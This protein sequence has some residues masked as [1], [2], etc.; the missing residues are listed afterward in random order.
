MASYEKR[1][2]E[3]K[4]AISILVTPL[5]N[6]FT[7]L[8]KAVDEYIK[9][10]DEVLTDMYSIAADVSDNLRASDWKEKLA[11][12]REA[13]RKNLEEALRSV[14]VPGKAALDFQNK[15]V[16]DE[17]IFWK[18]FESLDVGPHRDVL[19]LRRKHLQA[20]HKELDEK[21]SATVNENRPFLEDCRRATKELLEH[22][23]RAI[24]QTA[25]LLLKAKN[26]SA[27]AYT[28]LKEAQE[29][30]SSTPAGAALIAEIRA[31]LLQAN[32]RYKDTIETTEQTLDVMRHVWK[33]EYE[34]RASLFRQSLIS[35][36]RVLSAVPNARRVTNEFLEKGGVEVAR[37]EYE[38][39][40]KAIEHWS[41]ELPTDGLK[42]DARDIARE[43]TAK[44]NEHIKEMDKAFTEFTAKHK[45]KL[46][47]EMAGDI[48]RELI[49]YENGEYFVSLM[50]GRGL[51]TKLREWNVDGRR[52]M[53]LDFEEIFRQMEERLRDQ[54]E[55][56]SRELKTYI[57]AFKNELQREA[58]EL[59][60][61][62]EK[63]FEEAARIYGT[64][65][66]RKVFETKSQL[67]LVRGR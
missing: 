38:E 53:E 42:D 28:E 48:E 62:L 30:I 66:V 7:L 1:K 6:E 60:P 27:D 8:D 31:Y 32:R 25:G 16:N 58:R 52:A 55:E 51:E 37:K 19:M 14:S 11:K 45:G 33:A 4:N 46:F 39:L 21:W 36:A 3:L 49:D 5:S 12:G 29:Y 22:V 65:N 17:N 44:L 20:Y 24:E 23:D 41:N 67:D 63:A 18:T 2:K 59:I 54:P 35:K 10:R 26:A 50:S 61:Q 13:L 9:A 47:G 64:E 40:S 43:L 56:F 57:D 15:T 34:M